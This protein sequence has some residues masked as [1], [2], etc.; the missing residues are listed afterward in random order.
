ME[1]GLLVPIL[2]RRIWSDTRR[3]LLQP[4]ELQY[5]A[6]RGWQE[7]EGTAER[8]GLCRSH[9]VRRREYLLPVGSQLGIIEVCSLEKYTADDRVGRKAIPL[10]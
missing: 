2:V 8:D 6:S 1:S 3:A 4:A 5:Q 7:P 10:G 9:A